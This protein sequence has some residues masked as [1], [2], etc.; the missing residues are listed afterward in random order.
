M[1]IR[2]S[3]QADIDLI[4]SYLYGFTNFGPVQADRYERSLR[5][6]MGLIAENPRLAAEVKEFRPAV[7][8]HHVGKHF[9]IY[10]IRRDHILIVRI[11]PEEVDIRQHLDS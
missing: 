4:D 7:R 1:E 6:A 5:H 11:L 2:F 9:I 3:N 10:M 8:I